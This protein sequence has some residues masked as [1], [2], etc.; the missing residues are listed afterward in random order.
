MDQ[1][2][3]NDCKVMFH[4]KDGMVQNVCKLG[5]EQRYERHA[6]EAHQKLKNLQDYNEEKKKTLH[7]KM[8]KDLTGY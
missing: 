2:D 4:A 1:I 3:P 6:P 7:Q 5:L 8:L